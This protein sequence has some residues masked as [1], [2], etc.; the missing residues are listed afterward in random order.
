MVATS[1]HRSHF[2]P[3]VDGFWVTSGSPANRQMASKTEKRM[4]T[5]NKI[6]PQMNWL[7]THARA[8]HTQRKRFDFYGL[9]SYFMGRQPLK[10]I[11]F[12]GTALR[13]AFVLPAT[14]ETNFYLFFLKCF[15]LFFRFSSVPPPAAPHKPSKWLFEF[16]SIC[17]AMST[18][19]IIKSEITMTNCS[20][21]KATLDIDGNAP[22]HMQTTAAKAIIIIAF[23][24][25]VWFH[26]TPTVGRFSL[27]FAF[28]F[29]LESNLVTAPG[30]QLTSIFRKSMKLKSM[31]RLNGKSPSVDYLFGFLRRV[32]SLKLCQTDGAGIKK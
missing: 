2:A 18:W 32:P 19:K 23:Y 21:P 13:L 25:F 28:R 29:L 1:R 9:A 30:D 10:L 24:D 6:A 11:H 15:Y 7:R 5:A 12:K 17:I 16:N 26:A 20:P 31:C 22:M 14:T 4:Q 3:N 8:P 27:F